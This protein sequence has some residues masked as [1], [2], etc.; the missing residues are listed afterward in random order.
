MT[1]ISI[2]RKH[3]LGLERAK[4]ASQRV[5]DKLSE[6]F[7]LESHWEGNAL[8]FARPGVE[9]R[10]DVSET[11]VDVKIELGLML[12]AFAAPIEQQLAASIDKAIAAGG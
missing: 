4:A 2:N 5:V 3:T 12:A 1:T 8:K 9:G 6:K 11:Q 10:L 7:G